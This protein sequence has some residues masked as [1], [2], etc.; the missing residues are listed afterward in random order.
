MRVRVA[1]WVGYGPERPEF[2]RVGVA[3]WLGCG[4]ERLQFSGVGA[5]VWCGSREGGISGFGYT[6]DWIGG[7]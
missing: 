7:S 2:S 3:A 6:G 4:P 5:A 1:V